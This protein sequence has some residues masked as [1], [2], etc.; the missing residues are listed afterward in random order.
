M[1][2]STRLFAFI[3][4][5]STSSTNF[6]V[7]VY[8]IGSIDPFAND[9][10][11]NSNGNPFVDSSLLSGTFSSAGLDSSKAGCLATLSICSSICCRPLCVYYCYYYKC[12]GLAVVSIQSSYTF[13][14]K[15]KC[16]SPFGNLVSCSLFTSWFCSFSCLSYGDVIYSTSYFCSLSCVSWELSSVVSL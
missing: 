3:S 16:S 7:L 2:N 12:C 5:A 4:F 11:S 14:S 8:V 15:C 13:A 1:N 9:P 6:G 10:S